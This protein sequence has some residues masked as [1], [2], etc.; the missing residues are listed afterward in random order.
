MLSKLRG[1]LGKGLRKGLS[2]RGHTLVSSELPWIKPDFVNQ[3]ICKRGT[4]LF[5]DIGANEGQSV[6]KL[7]TA[8]YR[9]QVVS[10]EPQAEP[11]QQLQKRAALDD[12]WECHHLA[13]GETSGEIEMNISAHSQSSSILPIGQR[14]VELMPFTSEVGKSFVSIKRLDDWMAE[15]K[16]SHSGNLFLKIDV[17][18]YESP[19]LRGSPE[20]LSIADGVYIELNFAD[21]F[22]GQ[23]KYYDVMKLLE[24]SGL[25]LFGL[26]DLHLDPETN[27]Y[28]WGDGLF[29]RQAK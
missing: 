25:R 19:L 5:L 10:F 12:A 29:L 27:G 9:G 15:H 2:W 26:F 13:L 18:G 6:L 4:T 17:Q 16:P 8:G 28:L 1:L 23:S 22:D 11:F 21:L 7:R 20:T 3:M 14:H 24:E